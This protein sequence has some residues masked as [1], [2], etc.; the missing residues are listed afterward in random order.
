MNKNFEF[1][2]IFKD[3]LTDQEFDD[4]I[5]RA[6]KILSVDPTSIYDHRVVNDA[7]NQRKDRK[8][9][10]EEQ[11]LRNPKNLFQY[12]KR[13]TK[14]ASNIFFL[15]ELQPPSQICNHNTNFRC[16]LHNRDC[17]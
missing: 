3:E 2:A 11:Q 17:F 8:S 12:K 13:V 14:Q 16:W 5:K 6:N 4:A 10:K 7:V 15:D 1:T 9:K